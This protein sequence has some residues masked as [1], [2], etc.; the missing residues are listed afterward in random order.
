MPVGQD[1]WQAAIERISARPPKPVG[2]GRPTQGRGAPR[3]KAAR[4]VL[5]P[6]A[7]APRRTSDW[8]KALSKYGGG[9]GK[10]IEKQYAGRFNFTEDQVAESGKWGAPSRFPPP[11]DDGHG[12][13]D[14][15]GN[16]AGNVFD[17]GKGLFQ[18]GFSAG[19][20]VV[21]APIGIYGG[22]IGRIPGMGGQ[23]ARDISR[24]WMSELGRGAVE[25]VK[26]SASDWNQVIHGNFQPLYENPVF[27]GLD[28]LA[29]ITGGQTAAIR[30]GARSGRRAKATARAVAGDARVV[31]RTKGVNLANRKGQ[32]RPAWVKGAAEA[33]DP[34]LG[35]QIEGADRTIK[36]RYVNWASNATRPSTRYRTPLRI[37]RE[38][39][40]FDLANEHETWVRTTVPVER[41]PR[42][43]TPMG[44]AV[45]APFLKGIDLAVAKSPALESRRLKR[46]TQRAQDE[47][48]VEKGAQVLHEAGVRGAANAIRKIARDPQASV[49]LTAHVTG[50]LSS[51][52]VDG[53]ELSPRQ[54]RDAVVAEARKN[55][56]EFKHKRRNN[57]DAWITNEETLKVFES[58]PDDLLNLDG[59][60]KRSRQVAKAVE[61]VRETGKKIDEQDPYGLGDIG[62]RDVQMESRTRRQRATIGK[63]EWVE[64]AG[65]KGRLVVADEMDRIRSE[66][67]A[68][69]IRTGQVGK[70]L[71]T[72]AKRGRRADG[73]EVRRW[74]TENRPEV[75]QAARE[76]GQDAVVSL[77]RATAEGRVSGKDGRAAPEFVRESAKR[78]VRTVDRNR[79]KQESARESRVAL[80]RVRGESGAT[81][82]VPG[83]KKVPK[84]LRTRANNLREGE[85]IERIEV[86]AYSAR[87]R[88][89]D[90]GLVRGV[91][92][93]IVE[94]AGAKVAPEEGPGYLIGVA[95]G[96]V[97]KI[98][99]DK[100]AKGRVLNLRLREAMD[101]GGRMPAAQDAIDKTLNDTPEGRLARRLLESG[102]VS[103][104]EAFQVR[105]GR[106]EDASLE[107]A[108]RR[109]EITS[110]KN[111][112]RPDEPR[113]SPKEKVDRV[114]EVAVEKQMRGKL[115]LR[116]DGTIDWSNG[117]ALK[118]ANDPMLR[119]V[120][121]DEKLLS[122]VPVDKDAIFVSDI[123]TGALGQ[124]SARDRENRQAVT[125]V[126]QDAKLY[127]SEA[128]LARRLAN[129]YDATSILLTWE[130]LGRT[131]GTRNFLNEVLYKWAAKEAGSRVPKLLDL[132]EASR[133]DPN[134][135]ALL[136][137]SSFP[138]AER[139]INAWSPQNRYALANLRGF[140][141]KPDELD[142][143]G[144]I[145]Q[146]YVVPREVGDEVRW[147]FQNPSKV[148]QR[149]DSGMDLWR[150]GVLALAPRWYINNFIGNTLFYGTFTGF[151]L[152]ALRLA[153]QS[154]TRERLPFGIEGGTSSVQGMA[155]PAEGI[156]SRSDLNSF[157]RV[158]RALGGAAIKRTMEAGF[159][160]N[161]TIESVVRRA[162]YIHAAKRLLRDEGLYDDRF[163]HIKRQASDA[164]LLEAIADMPDYLKREA[165]REMKQWM[166]DYSGLSR[167]E[168]TWMRRII[169]FYSWLRVI[170]TWVFGL[171]FRSPLRAEMLA[172]A[173]RIGNE[174]QGDRRYLPWWE[175]GRIESLLGIEG[176]ALRTSGMNPLMSIAEPLT[177]FGND[178]MGVYSRLAELLRTQGGG[179][180]PLL[181]AGIGAFSGVNPFGNRGY[182]APV[183]YDG[184]VAPFGKDP[185]FFNE[186]TGQIDSRNTPANLP[187]EIFQ[188]L[189]FAPQVRALLSGTDR[190]Y[191]T[192]G[193]WEL[194]ANRLGMGKGDD[195]LYQPPQKDGGTG[196]E[197]IPFISPIAGVA[198]VPIYRYDKAREVESDWVRRS[199]Y[200]RAKRDTLRLQR[201]QRNARLNDAG[202]F[203]G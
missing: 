168:R 63:A 30:I 199:R 193:T 40:P 10:G 177:Q 163:P 112:K 148:A 9:N 160:V 164:D 56:Q 14:F 62:W 28:A 202:K 118:I 72:A 81:A 111:D 19:K 73:N 138:D 190:P 174:I 80:Y 58:L 123:A 181:G 98:E 186:I 145:G 82:W 165:M 200:E 101:E 155:S 17:I 36:G 35:R 203:V 50:M 2:I 126:G 196:R 44:R 71:R 132:T 67:G 140:V 143:V 64:D 128:R 166:G 83:G 15:V 183:G 97:K 26:A 184:T 110:R 167:F 43:R 150:G 11:K 66:Y 42:A 133:L 102:R 87:K 93:K 152:N 88:Q 1:S 119:A 180:N 89:G 39:V 78:V 103:I 94:R 96:T 77:L 121:N 54:V 171:P 12:V 3:A 59:S 117:L 69:V 172:L 198:G 182:T 22:T 74:L 60:T 154:G 86:P 137:K 161:Q 107:A 189:P 61:V 129:S 8:D 106:R 49:A 68:G 21:G 188:L 115:P 70:L 99:G 31:Q 48:G 173:G 16:A 141:L 127:R 125:P 124:K 179:V 136:P 170:N 114:I 76:R 104:D 185:Q 33:V 192:A 157:G 151:D 156:I 20:A 178:D 65:P 55:F 195:E 147:L 134:L 197:T 169:P 187:E 53:V 108:A 144:D 32:V 105:P 79:R 85:V 162:A 158:N 146:V 47:L 142:D 34:G 135:W 120:M 27:M 52:K 113:L 57:E 175:Q 51:R 194:L 149:F 90:D 23:A 38:A 100:A 95:A 92:D 116:E 29:P 159:R 4:P 13:W 7:G 24:E 201:R 131:I 6:T 176:L 18:A 191:D 139:A 46:S 25:G 5:R 122:Q 37:Q 109:G 41:R 130:R 75:V 91:P 153:N 45:Q 84:A